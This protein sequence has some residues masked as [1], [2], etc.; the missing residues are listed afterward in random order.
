MPGA[1][2]GSEN[3]DTAERQDRQAIHDTNQYDENDQ[4]RMEEWKGMFA[5]VG[6]A[7]PQLPK[8]TRLC[9]C[10]ERIETALLWTSGDRPTRSTGPSHLI[11]NNIDID[12][13][14]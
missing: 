5:N 9:S 8:H 2:W 4:E 12:R 10:G 14:P 7:S 6:S 3:L 1:T 13:S 11:T